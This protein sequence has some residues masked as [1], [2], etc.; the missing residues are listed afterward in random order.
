M[1]EN[2]FL[3]TKKEKIYYNTEYRKR[4]K[5]LS[6]FN[7]FIKDRISKRDLIQEVRLKKKKKLLIPL[8]YKK[9]HYFYSLIKD[10]YDRWIYTIEYDILLTIEVFLLDKYFKEEK[11]FKYFKNQLILEFF[12][13]GIVYFFLLIYWLWMNEWNKWCSFTDLLESNFL[14]IETIFKYI[15]FYF[16]DFLRYIYISYN[17]LLSGYFCDLDMSDNS[18]NVY[19]LFLFDSLELFYV[20]YNIEKIKLEHEKSSIPEKDWKNLKKASFDYLKKDILNDSFNISFF[21]FGVYEFYILHAK[22]NNHYLTLNFFDYLTNCVIEKNYSYYLSLEKKKKIDFKFKFN[23]L[24]NLHISVYRKNFFSIRV[25]YNLFLS[26]IDYFLFMKDFTYNY[27]IRNCN[28]FFEFISQRKLFL[29]YNNPASINRGSLAMRDYDKLYK[30]YLLTAPYSN[31]NDDL[32]L[33]NMERDE[34]FF[35][36]YYKNFNESLAY[37]KDLYLKDLNVNFLYKLRTSDHFFYSINK[38]F[39]FNLIEFYNLKNKLDSYKD[40]MAINS[41]YE[42]RF[43]NSSFKTMEE[44]M[45]TI[46]QTP[47]ENYLYFDDL[48]RNFSYDIVFDVYNKI[49][50]NLFFKDIYHMNDND[51][52]KYYLNFLK[53]FS[54]LFKIRIYFFQFGHLWDLIENEKNE[55]LLKINVFSKFYYIFENKRL[56]YLV[57]KIKNKN[58]NKKWSLKNFFNIIKY[59]SMFYL[60]VYNMSILF[61]G[62]IYEIIFIYRFMSFVKVYDTYVW[63]LDFYDYYRYVNC[64]KDFYFQLVYENLEYSLIFILMN[65]KKIKNN[66]E[67][68]FLNR[69]NKIINNFIYRKYTLYTWL[70]YSYYDDVFIDLSFFSK[71]IY[72]M[73]LNKWILRNFYKKAELYMFYSESLG[74]KFINENRVFL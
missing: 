74:N 17:V 43:S 3:I 57:K 67:Y 23:G 11:L 73:K 46:F 39:D 18:I 1:I 30:K 56:F 19:N 64:F 7:I 15:N 20:L 55:N 69:K 16:F 13:D 49:S 29:K 42:Y 40:V 54:R 6:K 35:N 21:T 12:F 31:I 4:I 62:W 70:E 8:F 14:N 52:F 34:P 33:F 36:F 38:F 72:S 51:N 59:N 9:L 66:N 58:F 63:R 25:K 27:Y 61:G 44:F 68:N 50:K 60:D 22:Y 71:G 47:L 53:I 24:N 48:Y 10:A 41:V 37:I 32:D 26:N 65:I 5:A 2:F 28:Y 45:L